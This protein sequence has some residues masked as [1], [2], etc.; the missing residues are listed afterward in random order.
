ML[1]PC[2]KAAVLPLT[3]ASMNLPWTMTGT[4]VCHTWPELHICRHE[5]PCTVFHLPVN[6]LA[7]T[8]RICLEMLFEH[9]TLKQELRYT[10]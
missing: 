6:V 5:R 10:A 4:A 2:V 1:R 8:L 3:L 7:R 9:Q